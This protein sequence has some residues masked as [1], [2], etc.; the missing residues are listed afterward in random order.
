VPHK[1]AIEFVTPR[2][3]QAMRGTCWDFAT[4]AMLEQSYRAQG[5]ANGWLQP[6]QFVAL[7]EQAYGVAVLEQCRV[8]W[9]ILQILLPL[10]HA[11]YCL[12]FE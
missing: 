8:C 4:I 10:G 1:L 7:S 9:P 2:E 6:D 11:H 5:V 3:D 12:F